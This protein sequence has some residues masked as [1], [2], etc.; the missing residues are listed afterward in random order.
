MVSRHLFEQHCCTGSVH[1]NA[2]CVCSEDDENTAQGHKKQEPPTCL[3]SHSVITYPSSML[4]HCISLDDQFVPFIF[5]H[6]AHL[7]SVHS[8]RVCR[9][10]CES[11]SICVSLP[12]VLVYRCATI[13]QRKLIEVY[14]S[15]FPCILCLPVCVLVLVCVHEKQPQQLTTSQRL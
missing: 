1:W 15:L 5:R 14:L 9:F 3:F 7:S 4:I 6:A 12:Y 13:S 10:S 11:C 8:C 2:V